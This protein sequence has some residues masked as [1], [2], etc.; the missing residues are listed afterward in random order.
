MICDSVPCFLPEVIQTS[1]YNNNE[2]LWLEP[3]I[4]ELDVIAQ[5]AADEE[6][7]QERE[8]EE[9]GDKVAEHLYSARHQMINMSCVS[10]V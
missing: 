10:S 1:I 9:P 2:P 4:R 8:S 3:I 7:C 5:V 6:I